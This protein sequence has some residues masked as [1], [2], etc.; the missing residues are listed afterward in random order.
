VDDEINEQLGIERNKSYADCLCYIEY[1]AMDL[2]FHIC[3]FIEE[4]PES[5]S[6]FSKFIE[7]YQRLVLPSYGTF[8]VKR[9]APEAQLPSKSRASDAGYDLTAIKVLKTHGIVTFYDTG[10]I[11]QPEYGYYFDVVPRSSLSK[12]GYILA[13]SVGVIDATYRGTVIL[14]LMKIDPTAPDITLPARICQM[15]PRRLHHVDIQE[16]ENV[17]ETERGEKGFGS[18]NIYQAT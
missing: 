6:S 13:N 16:V 12:S 11:V 1:A 5:N 17:D 3:Q 7:E 8:R 14:A 18:S 2:G 15:I 10:I 9:T 4:C